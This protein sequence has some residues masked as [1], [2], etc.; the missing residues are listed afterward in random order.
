M[1]RTGKRE[2][3][4]SMFHRLGSVSAIAAVSLVAPFWI[5]QSMAAEMDPFADM[6]AVSD[7]ELD[8]MRGGYS[9][10]GININFAIDMRTFVNGQEYQRTTMAVQGQEVSLT[11]TVY[12]DEVE[13]NTNVDNPGG[14]PTPVIT[15]SADNLRTL[16]QNGGGNDAPAI[17]D[18]DFNGIATLVQNTVDGAVIQ[19]LTTV[20]LSV[21]DASNAIKANNLF[22]GLQLHGSGLGL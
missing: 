10:N 9:F 13:N 17:N 14:T 22:R 6:E 12:V 19:Q 8:S 5:E 11:K 7:E 15:T 18:L 20:D 4:W 1:S 16:I 2:M 3:G 21:F